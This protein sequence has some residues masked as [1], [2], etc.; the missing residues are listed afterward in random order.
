MGYPLELV[1]DPM[2]YP[3]YNFVIVVISNYAQL[4]RYLK[5]QAVED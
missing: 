5:L 1:E 2:K 4:F 3:L